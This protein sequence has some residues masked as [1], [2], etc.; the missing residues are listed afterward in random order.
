M[1]EHYTEGT[2]YVLLWCNF[3]QRNT[4]HNVS[5]GRAGR[6]TEHAASGPSQKQKKQ[7]EKATREKQ[8][9]SL[10][11]KKEDTDK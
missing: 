7:Q 10:F 9:P 1:T 8:N 4:Q 3:C 6:C 11:E 2:E 5:G